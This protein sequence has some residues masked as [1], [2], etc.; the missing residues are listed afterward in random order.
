MESPDR[1]FENLAMVSAWDEAFLTVPSRYFLSN[2]FPYG[3]LGISHLGCCPSPLKSPTIKG[4]TVYVFDLSKD[5]LGPFSS[6]A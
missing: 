5:H 1:K 2:V 4:A 3:G 6:A